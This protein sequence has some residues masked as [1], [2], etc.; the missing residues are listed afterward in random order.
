MGGDLNAR[1]PGNE[2][3]RSISGFDF[4]FIGENKNV[5]FKENIFDRIWSEKGKETFIELLL[6][7]YIILFLLSPRLMPLT[8]WRQQLS[9]KKRSVIK[10]VYP[11]KFRLSAL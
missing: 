8:A 7:Q 1:D 5:N 3:A 2:A 6:Q 10:L 11:I 4:F 9:V